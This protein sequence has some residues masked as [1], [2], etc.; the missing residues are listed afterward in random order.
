MSGSQLGVYLVPHHKCARANSRRKG[1][2]SAGSVEE[3]RRPNDQAVFHR[4]IKVDITGRRR[5]R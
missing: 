1:A 3:V 2:F 4:E 5:V